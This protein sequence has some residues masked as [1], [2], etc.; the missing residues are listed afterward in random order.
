MDFFY[1]SPPSPPIRC[2]SGTGH[3]GRSL[4]FAPIL[5]AAGTVRGGGGLAM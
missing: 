4:Y 5:R 3:P 1:R 2:A